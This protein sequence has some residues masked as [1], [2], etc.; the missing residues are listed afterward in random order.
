MKCCYEGCCS[1]QVST[2]WVVEVRRPSSRV[3]T[4]N[5]WTLGFHLSRIGD[6]FMHPTIYIYIYSNLCIDSRCAIRSTTTAFQLWT[7]HWYQRF[8]VMSAQIIGQYKLEGWRIL[9]WIKSF[10]GPGWPGLDFHS[11]SIKF[12]LESDHFGALAGRGSIFIDF[13]LNSYQKATILGPCLAGARFSLLF[14]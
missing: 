3:A 7:R 2:L 9:I 6:G 8:S 11:W 10:W 4:K 14:N 5:S 13:Q 1:I 12:F